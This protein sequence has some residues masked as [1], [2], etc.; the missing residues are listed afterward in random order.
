MRPTR[1][2]RTTAFKLA[3]IYIALFTTSALVLLGVVWWTTAG[4]MERQT[5]EVI[6]AE[7]QGLAEQYRTGGLT[8]LRRAIEERGA[9]QPDRASIYLLVDPFLQPVAGNIDGWPQVR[10]SSD[11]WLRFTVETEGKARR[12]ERHRAL[13]RGYRLGPGFRLLVGRDIEE[14]LHLQGLVVRAIGWG[15]GLTLLLGLAGGVLMS[16]QLLR[17][18]DAINRTTRGIIDGDLSRRIE[19]TGSRDEFDQLAA[20]LNAMLDRIERLLEGMRQVTDNIAHDLRTPLNRIRS[21]IEVA[22]LA[23]PDS[24]GSAREVLQATLRD[25]EELIGT[26]NALLAIARA[27]AGAPEAGTEPLDLA[28]LTRD[29]AELYQPLAE[30]KGLGFAVEANGRPVV[31]AN[32]HLIAQ[33]LANLIDNAVKYTPSGGAVRVEAGIGSGRRPTLLVADTGPG[34]PEEQRERVL[35]RFVRLDQ[36]RS[37]P[38]NGL[39]L[40]LVRAVARLHGAALR[41]ED[42]APG[43]RVTIAFPEAE[44][45]TADERGG[46]RGEPA[47]TTPTT[48]AAEAVGA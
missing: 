41:L 3:L 48:P 32:R 10:S 44:K 6:Q 37:T 19:L 11:G 23:D 5:A 42:N 26:F 46:R 9:A 1:L 35:E 12:A 28:A 7:V 4:F 47:P 45:A 39:G 21:R 16:R 38:G 33:A 14:R 43:L 20:N 22:L 18:V 30:D 17:R 29:V 25:A 27:E 24:A 13:G 36:D 2:V 15:M 40:S 8:G 31:R 34:I